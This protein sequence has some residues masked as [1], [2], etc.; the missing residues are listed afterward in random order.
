MRST[1]NAL[2]AALLAALCLAASSGCGLGQTMTEVT[3]E[4]AESGRS[5]ALKVGQTLLVKLPDRGGA[6]FSWQVEGNDTAILEPGPSRF[7]TPPGG[8]GGGSQS[9]PFKALKAGRVELAFKSRR[10]WERDQPPAQ[11][12]TF[13]VTV[14]ER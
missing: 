10:P 8:A 6:G 14:T 11:T 9:L 1:R 13:T 2:H 7:E 5:V 4:A 12:V 3:V